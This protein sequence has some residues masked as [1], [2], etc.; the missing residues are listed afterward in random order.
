MEQAFEWEQM[1][2]L[3]YPYF[4]GRKSVWA[5]R[6]AFEDADPLF[7]QFLKA[8]YCRAVVPVRPGF[9]GAVDHFMTFGEPWMGGPL[10]P[11]SSPQYVPIAEE[12]AER[13]DRPGDEVPV[14]EPWE[15]KIPTN[16]VRLRDD[17]SLPSWRQNADGTWIPD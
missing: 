9:E 16:L 14:G 11:I 6:V 2:W 10:P 1:T 13:L 8:G 12:I 15:V 5:D 3:T 17:G 7:S 4:W